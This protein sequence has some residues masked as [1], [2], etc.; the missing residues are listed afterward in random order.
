MKEGRGRKDNTRR[1]RSVERWTEEEGREREE[2]QYE[3][4]GERGAM[5]R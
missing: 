4:D 3:E 2:G 5:L 1:T